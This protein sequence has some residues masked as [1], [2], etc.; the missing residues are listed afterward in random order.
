MNKLDWAQFN[1]GVFLVN[2]LSIIYN[3]Q[4]KMVLIGRREND[5]YIK[6]LS[7]S[8]PGGR[9][10]YDL[11]LEDYLRLEVK[12]KTGLEISV[13]RIVFAKTYPERR[14][15]MSIYY[16]CEVTGGVEQAGE[17]FKEIKWV[18]PNEVKQYFT[19]S[20]SPKLFEFLESLE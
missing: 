7:W 17:K 15:F 11:N 16:L 10:G 3:P 1:R 6:G 2:A 4:T 18:K 12:K 8:F 19:T 13:S 14:E 9:P 20:V 5:Q